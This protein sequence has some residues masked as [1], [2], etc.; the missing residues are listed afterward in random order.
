MK[1]LYCIFFTFNCLFGYVAIAQIG[2]QNTYQFLNLPV[3]PRHAA[4]GGKNVTLNNYD[5][6]SALNNPALINDLMDRNLSVNYMNFVGDVN[7]GTASYGHF[8][9]EEPELFRLG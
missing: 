9:T 4:L 8:L 2:G 3:S 7:Y 5:P 6:T 1:Y